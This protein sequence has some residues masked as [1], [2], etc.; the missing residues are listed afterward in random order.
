MAR[1]WVPGAPSG[2]PGPPLSD[3]SS[4]TPV[5]V[6]PPFGLPEVPAEAADKSL[7]TTFDVTEALR[8]VAPLWM[9]LAL[10][11]LIG[12]ATLRAALLQCL[13]SRVLPHA[14][15]DQ[16]RARLEPLL[17][18]VDKLATSATLLQSTAL[19]VFVGLLID[20][21]AG[22]RALRARD[23]AISLAIAAPT[24][25]LVANALPLA[26]ARAKGDVLLARVLPTFNL[27]QLPI[28]PLSSVLDWVR[29]AMLRILRVP[30]PRGA[31]RRIV[32]GLRGVLEEA[33]D[34]RELDETER[35]LIENV[36]DFRDVDAAEVMT[37]R[38]EITAVD[39][40]DGVEA[41]EALAVKHRKSRLPVFEGNIDTIIGT[42]S[43]LDLAGARATA[44]TGEAG[45][46]ALL[47]P[48]VL[49]PETKLVSALLNDFRDRREKMAIVVDE[50]GGTA[51]IATVTDAMREIFGDLAEPADDEDRIRTISPGL[52]AVPAALHVSDVNESLDLD[53]P[54]EEDYETLAGFVLAQLGHLPKQGEGFDHEG[55]RY[56]IAEASDRRVLLVQVSKV[57]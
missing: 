29:G 13:T 9:A 15:D 35:E 38:T 53:L 32:E 50:Y 40:A 45:L 17:E 43:A 46:R 39:V 57:A 18:R 20:V 44:Q 49:V 33:D 19:I 34:D 16:R 28:S 48:P 14:R 2:S 6:H 30:N 1:I 11:A 37:P 25:F 21:V 31:Q 22:G 55:V 10:L 42:V 56:D 47:R 23:L 52:F 54:E 26:L 41:A 4:S 3:L 36:M 12:L 5:I 27:L 7:T 24:L 8:A 51:G